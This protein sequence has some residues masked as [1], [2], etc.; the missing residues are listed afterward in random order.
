LNQKKIKAYKKKNY[1]GNMTCKCH[2]CQDGIGVKNIKKA[3]VNHAHHSK[4]LKDGW[5][6]YIPNFAFK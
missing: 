5:A 1:P 6:K 3:C 4:T 2:K